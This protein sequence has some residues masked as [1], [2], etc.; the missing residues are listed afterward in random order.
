MSLSCGQLRPA[1]A[2]DTTHYGASSKRPVSPPPRGSSDSAGEACDAAPDERQSRGSGGGEDVRIRWVNRWI[3][4]PGVSVPPAHNQAGCAWSSTSSNA[5]CPMNHLCPGLPSTH[6]DFRVPCRS[7]LRKA[8]VMQK[9][10]WPLQYAN[11]SVLAP[12]P[13]WVSVHRHAGQKRNGGRSQ[14]GSSIRSAPGRS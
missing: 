8:L 12:P 10:A 9:A 4:R 1:H 13:S 7:P 14:Q 6:E 3:F 11:P 5:R 2:P